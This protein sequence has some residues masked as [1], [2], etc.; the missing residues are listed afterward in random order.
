MARTTSSRTA[1]KSGGSKSSGKTTTKATSKP[2]SK[3]TTKATSK[4][5]SLKTSLKG[6]KTSSTSKSHETKARESLQRSLARDFPDMS[7]KS[8]SK[9]EN[10]FINKVNRTKQDSWYK[11]RRAGQKK[12]NWLRSEARKCEK[13]YARRQLENS[14][15]SESSIRIPKNSKRG[16]WTGEN[17]KS[18]YIP[19]EIDENKSVNDFLKDNEVD[20]IDY[21]NGKP[22]LYL[23]ADATVKISNDKNELDDSEKIYEALAEQF[24][25]NEKDGR[26]NWT[27]EE[28]KDYC[29]DPNK[30]NGFRLVPHKVDD[31][32]C[33]FVREDVYSF[34]TNSLSDKQKVQ[35]KEETGW[36]EEIVEHIDNMDQ[37]DIYKG[38]D[39]HELEIDGRKC[40]CKNIDMNFVDPK[41]GKTNKEL[42]EQGKAPIDSKTGEKIELHHMQQDFEGPFAELTSTEHGGINDTILHDKNKESFRNDP[43]KNN[44]YNNIDRPNHWK[45]RSK[46]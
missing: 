45:E 6:E 20:G 29:E 4:S 24:N 18:R 26:N 35:I 28:A 41:T 32:T 37:Y 44:Q 8:R 25:N 9:L 27:T 43:E 2:T 38:A 10:S 11:A 7:E 16:T 39:L 14:N 34:F 3:T 33:D 40:L 13:E 30:H 17:G 1:S 22:D 36:S 23:L 19:S 12:E 15:I 46:E 42:M 5:S 31:A 21:N